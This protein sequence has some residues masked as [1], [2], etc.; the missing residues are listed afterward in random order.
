METIGP[1]VS[2]NGV[3]STSTKLPARSSEHSIAD[4]LSRHSGIQIQTQGGPYLRTALYR[5]QSARHMAILWEGVNIQNSFN[6]TYDLGLI[7]SRIF[8]QSK[9][10]DGG[11]SANIGTAAMSGA[12]VLEEGNNDPLISLGLRYNDQ[13]NRSLNLGIQHGV[14]RFSHSLQANV[15]INKNAFRFLSRDT[16]LKRTNSNHN[17]LDLAYRADMEWS[18]SMRTHIS[19]WFQDVDRQL[20]PSIIATNIASQEDRNHRLSIG[21]DWQWAP[22]LYWSTKLAY[23]NEYI[24]YMQPGIESLAES[25]IVNLNSKIRIEGTIDH[26]IGLTYRYEDG[27]LVDTIN[28]SFQSFFP[29]RTTAA[30]YYNGIA[31]KDKTTLSIS[32]RQEWIDNNIQTPTGQLSLRYDYSSQLNFTLNA[33]RH[34]SYPGFNDLYWPIGGNPD[35]ITEKSWQIEGG[36]GFSGL[37]IKLYQIYTADKILWAP[38]EQSIWTPDNVASTKSSGFE[39]KYNQ[40]I[41]IGKDFGLTLIPIFNYNHTINTAEGPNEGNELLYNPKLNLRFNTVIKYKQLSLSMDEV[42]V[43]RR[44]QSLDNKSVLDSY[45][46][47]N[48]EINYNWNSKQKYQAEIYF[49]MRNLV[50]ENYELV[51]FYPQPLRSIY[52]GVNFSIQ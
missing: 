31:K 20:A 37:I 52:I 28:A 19:Y 24:G 29:K 36:I 10:Y 50:D 32:L 25:D 18:D 14:D 51:R 17:Q 3:I 11:Q 39:F 46:L 5:G 44:Y 40:K 13:D 43:G 1:E 8:G 33:G 2:I 27:A 30:V 9:W 35:L 49:G 6:G 42:F 23:M 21:H 22:N 47:L 4:L 41:N 15:L 45:N 48:V 7:S 16:V 12:L 34:Y 38:N 26:T